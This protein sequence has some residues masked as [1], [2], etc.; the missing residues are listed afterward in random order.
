MDI[1]LPKIKE[2]NFLMDLGQI[3]LSHEE[4]KTVLFFLCPFG[5]AFA[6]LIFSKL[7]KDYARH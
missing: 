2:D 7:F 1:T 5:V 4:L 6:T 3:K